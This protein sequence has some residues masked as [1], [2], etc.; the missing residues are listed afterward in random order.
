MT[1]RQ[2]TT[3]YICSLEGVRGIAILLIILSHCTFATNAYGYSIFRY[4]GAFGVEIF[5][6][7]SGYLAYYNYL[8]KKSTL[9]I[10]ETLKRKV[11]K[12]YPL[13]IITFIAALPLCLYI[14]SE[15]NYIKTGMNIVLNLLMLN[16][17]IP[18]MGVYFSFNSVA[19]YLTLVTFF[20]I[21]APIFI[22]WL[23]EKSDKTLI[24]IAVVIIIGKFLWAGFVQGN[25]IEHWLIYICPIA[26]S[27][28]FLMGAITYRIIERARINKLRRIDLFSIVSVVMSA[29][30]LYV[31]LSIDSVYFLTAIWSIPAILL[32]GVSA[33]GDNESKTVTVLFQ[34]SIIVFIGKISFELF[35]IHQLVIRYMQV[36]CGKSGINVGILHYMIAILTAVLVA[37]AWQKFSSVLMDKYKS[38]RR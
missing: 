37:Y 11:K 32:V 21:I 27:L 12:L 15:A 17:W 30:I 33:L 5:I 14:F 28:D 18:K 26:R 34:N 6:V 9:S 38:N 22:K 16:A 13:H 19:W 1:T 4:A 31:S 36:L 23:R 10:G 29:V 35:L 2:N 24:V 25:P 8:G 7:L 20:I 3:D